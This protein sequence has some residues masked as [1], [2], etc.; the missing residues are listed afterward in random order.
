MGLKP[1]DSG[2]VHLFGQNPYTL[3]K[4][5]LRRFRKRFR[6]IFRTRTPRSIPNSA[7]ATRLPKP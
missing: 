6:I 2:S 1:P 5:A 7:S 4:E 3:P